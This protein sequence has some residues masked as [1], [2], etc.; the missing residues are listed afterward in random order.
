MLNL[1]TQYRFSMKI[2]NI[3]QYKT[4]E[5]EV[6]TY[7]GR[8]NHDAKGLVSPG[9]CGSNRVCNLRTYV[10]DQ[11]HQHFLWICYGMNATEHIS[12]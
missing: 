4:A 7:F 2:E 6:Q 9:R 10:R 1:I 12:W 11:V 3:T 8:F 5:C